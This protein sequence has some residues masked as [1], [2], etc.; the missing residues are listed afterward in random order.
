VPTPPSS[1]PAARPS[2]APELRRHLLSLVAGVIALDVVALALK[3]WLGVDDWP[4]GRQRAFTVGW[5]AV[6]LLVVS[7]FLQRIRVAR[8]R[9]RRSRAGRP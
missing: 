9:A 5:V 6:T 4:S 1:A 3:A 2:A 7:V 8:V